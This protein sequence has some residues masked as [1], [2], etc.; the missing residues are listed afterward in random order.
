VVQDVKQ[1]EEF[2]QLFST[3]KDVRIDVQV[4]SQGKI[5]VYRLDAYVEGIHG[6]LDFD[7]F[8]LEIDLSFGGW[9]DA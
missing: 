3:Q 4:F 8:S 1:P 9:V 7:F 5:L 2:F 6:I